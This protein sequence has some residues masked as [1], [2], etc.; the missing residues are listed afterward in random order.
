MT[1]PVESGTKA[2]ITAEDFRNIT[3]N[4]EVQ[5]AGVLGLNL[6]ETTREILIKETLQLTD[7]ISELVKK[8]NAGDKECFREAGRLAE[9]KIKIANVL[10]GHSV[11]TDHFAQRTGD[12][13]FAICLEGPAIEQSQADYI[14]HRL[15]GFSSEADSLIHILRRIGVDLSKVASGP[16]QGVL[17]TDS[18]GKSLQ[19]QRELYEHGVADPI[20]GVNLAIEVILLARDKGVELKTKKD[21]SYEAK[22]HRVYKAATDAGLS[23]ASAT[24]LQMITYGAIRVEVEE[25]SRP[26]MLYVGANGCLSVNGSFASD[27]ASRW[28]LGRSAP[29]A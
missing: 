5:V 25:D 2:E 20:V 17:R 26:V 11:A 1:A 16:M 13:E 6:R 24:I 21:E 15:E 7:T 10:S 12:N 3:I 22:G 8:G 28:A 18:N 27:I 29:A 19:K 4:Q 9:Q 23:E 14:R